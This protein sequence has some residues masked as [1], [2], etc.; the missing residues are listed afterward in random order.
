MVA[1]EIFRARY[2]QSFEKPAPVTPDE[3]IEYTIDLHANN[4]RFLTGH[5]IMVQVQSTWFPLYEANPQSFVPNIFQA[6]DA[7][8][9]IATQRVYRSD[10]FPSSVEIPVIVH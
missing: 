8:A 1:D 10:R 6:T 5:K 2:R 3:V 7:N 4:H 9:R